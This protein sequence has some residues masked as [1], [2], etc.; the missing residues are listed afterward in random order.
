MIITSSEEV[1]ILKTIFVKYSRFD[2]YKYSLRNWFTKLSPDGYC[3]IIDYR[4]GKV[5]KHNRRIDL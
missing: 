1:E 4:I 5:M 3:D 2:E